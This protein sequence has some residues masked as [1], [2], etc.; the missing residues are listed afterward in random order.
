[1][2]DLKKSGNEMIRTMANPRIQVA[3]VGATVGIIG[4]ALGQRV[5]FSQMRG[6]FGWETENGVF[7]ATDPRSGRPTREVVPDVSRMFNLRRQAARLG[8]ALLAVGSLA[9]VKGDSPAAEGVRMGLIASA[10]T[11]LAHG[12]QDNVQALNP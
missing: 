10:G 5:L 3:A 12:I 9:L 11:L 7:R 6:T 1:M 2:S 8:L 4:T